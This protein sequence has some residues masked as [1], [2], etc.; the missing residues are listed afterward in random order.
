MRRWSSTLGLDHAVYEGLDSTNHCNRTG[1]SIQSVDL[2]TMIYKM[3]CALATVMLL[4]ACSFG[5]TY[6]EKVKLLTRGI[7]PAAAAKTLEVGSQGSTHSR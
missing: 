4:Q 1:P 5:V 7:Q 3:T 6:P 2:W